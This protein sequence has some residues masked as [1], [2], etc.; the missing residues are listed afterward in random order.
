MTWVL[1]RLVAALFLAVPMALAATA[2]PVPISPPS[3]PQ[4]FDPDP[5]TCQTETMRSAF[6]RQLAPYADQGEQVLRQLRAVQ[7]EITLA[8]LRSC[9]RR[10]L[11]AEEEA[12]R[13]G[14]E[15]GII[16]PAPQTRGS[17]RPA[18]NSPSTRP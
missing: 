10:G 14:R 2:R 16:T 8:S 13:L 12:V 18:T 3:Q 9:V 11:M 17:S 4:V 6:A 1:I 7:A 15:F 5:Q